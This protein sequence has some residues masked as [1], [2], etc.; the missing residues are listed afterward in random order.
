MG[1]CAPFPAW[2]PASARRPAGSSGSGAPG[3]ARAC[4]RRSRRTRGRSLQPRR[5]QEHRRTARR[6]PAL[7]SERRHQRR[8]A[9]SPGRG[10]SEGSRTPRRPNWVCETS[11]GTEEFNSNWLF[12]LTQVWN[13]ST[14]PE[15]EI[16]TWLW[17]CVC[18]CEAPLRDAFERGTWRRAV[19]L[20]R[21]GSDAPRRWWPGSCHCLLGTVKDANTQ[22]E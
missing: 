3:P 2:S 11:E 20:R 18:V 8:W 5:S 13:I 17:V 6:R 15:A 19:P 4:S 7:R 12:S 14:K 1:K 10:R 22:H 16:L 21:T 9:R